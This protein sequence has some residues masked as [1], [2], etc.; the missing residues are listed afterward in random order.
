MR[1]TLIIVLAVILTLALSVTSVTLAAGGKKEVNL[2]QE[3]GQSWLD[4]TVA[5]T[6]EPL[7]WIGAQL[8]APQVYYDLKGKPNAYMFAIENDGEVVGYITVGSSDYGYPMFEAAD[9][10]PP[11]IPSAD[12]VKSTLKRDLGLDV[13]SVGRPARLLY[14]GF[15]NIFAVYQADGQEVAVDLKFDVAVRVSNLTDIVAMPSPEEYKADKEA[16]EQAKLEELAD[17]NP[18]AQSRSSNC[19]LMFHWCYKYCA[20]CNPEYKCW[21][22]PSSGTSIGAYYKYYHSPQYTGLPEAYPNKCPMYLELFDEMSTSCSTGGTST[23]NYGPGFVQMTKNHG[24]YNFSHVTVKWPSNYYP[25]IKSYIDSGWPTALRAYRFYDD[26]GGNPDFPPPKA[27]YV[28]IKGYYD[29]WHGYDRV[30][31]CTDSYS[32]SDWLYLNYGILGLF[33][34]YITIKD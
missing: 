34:W 23:T 2:A 6:K 32:Q 19:L 30:L 9:V 27:H 11:S 20:D 29:G 22:G 13:A 21:C 16:A 10:P 1:K 3:A 7:E 5:V 15:D 18:T 17:S 14:L 4:S 8:T 33:P 26:I 28:A 24:Y 12:E 25:N 31:I